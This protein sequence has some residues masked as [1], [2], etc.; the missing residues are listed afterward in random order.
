VRFVHGVRWAWSLQARKVVRELEFEVDKGAQEHETALC[1]SRALV[2]L[3][4]AGLGF[5]AW[6]T[7]CAKAADT[8]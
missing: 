1:S 4:V 2:G 6:I 5:V 8:A 7:G 3:V